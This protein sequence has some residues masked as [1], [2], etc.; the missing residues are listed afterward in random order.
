MIVNWSIKARFTY[1]EI[2]DYLTKNWTKREIVNFNEKVLNI[3]EQI[4]LNPHS[5]PNMSRY[6]NIRK[7]KIMKQTSLFY[8]IEEESIS[9][10]FF[11]NQYRNPKHLEEYLASC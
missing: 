11:W 2:I 3:I 7:A 4:E 8:S 1:E 9:L 5:C 10:L 6:P